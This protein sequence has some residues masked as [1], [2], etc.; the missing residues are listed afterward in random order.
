M[1]KVL[2]IVAFSGILMFASCDKKEE[3]QEEVVSDTTSAMPMDTM[4]A[5]PMDTMSSMPM[6]TAA[7]K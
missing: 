3:K 1:K 4:S 7:A 5:M 2:S 6:D